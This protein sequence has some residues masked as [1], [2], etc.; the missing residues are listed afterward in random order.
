MDNTRIK[1]VLL[2]GYDYPEEIQ[3]YLEATGKIQSD[4]DEITKLAK[5]IMGNE[6]DIAKIASKAAKWTHDNI[7]YDKQLTQDISQGYIGS[8]DAIETLRLRKGTCSEYTNVF[9]AV[10]RNLGVPTRFVTG[11]IYKGSYHAW[12]E[13]YLKDVGWIP[14]DPQM[15][16][17]EVT[18]RH[19]KLLEGVDFPSLNVKLLQINANVRI[20]D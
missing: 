20:I 9:I 13:F 5:E 2:D 6:K 10:M 17:V 19:I 15:G 11:I 12:A 3:K 16:T 18:N 4:S 7:E 14:V 1:P 8:R